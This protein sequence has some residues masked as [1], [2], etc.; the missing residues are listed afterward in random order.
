MP[1]A[2]WR[3]RSSARRWRSVCSL[4][5]TGGLFVVT[6]ERLVHTPLGFSD[7]Q[8]AIVQ[9]EGAAHLTPDVWAGITASLRDTPGV[10]SAALAGWAPLTGNRWRSTVFA[11]GGPIEPRASYFVGVSSGY[12]ETMRIAMT[13]GRDFR[14]GDISP[15]V[16]DRQQPVAGVGIVNEAFAR[17]Y[18]DRGN[19]VGARVQVRQTNEVMATM[20]IVG[21][22]RDAVY[23]SVREPILPTVYCTDRTAER[24]RAPRPD[25]R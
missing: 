12:F 16:T 6:L 9:V 20:E 25:H 10:E 11:A 3:L 22:V 18:L 17:V 19:P 1:R 14:V 5:F 8:L 7:R 4:L 13:G 21:L 24:R 23:D 2:G 15:G